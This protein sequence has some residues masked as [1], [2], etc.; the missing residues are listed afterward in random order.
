MTFAKVMLAAVAALA[1][2]TAAA[3]AEPVKLRQGWVVAPADSPLFMFG[4]KGIT[5][6]EGKSY[7]LDTPRFQGTPPMITALAGGELD[8]V[9]FAYSSLGLAIENARMNDLRIIAD[10]FQDGVEGGYTNEYRVRNDSPIK[11]VEDL[12]GKVLAANVNGSALDIA[13][14]AMLR[15]HK[16]EDKRD[17]TIIEVGFPN[18][19]AVLAD[20]KVDLISAVLP[21][22]LDAELNSMS[23]VLFTQKDAIGRSQMIILTAKE[24]FIKKNRAALVDY[25]E[26][27]LRLLRWYEAPA[28]HAEA[29]QLVSAYTKI[30]E[31]ALD[32]WL[33]V[34]GKDYYRDPNAK[35]DINALQANVDLAQQLGFIK[36]KIDIKK[37]V[38]LSLAEEAAKRVK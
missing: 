29:V 16:M 26:D 9:P 33:F 34:K 21:F 6:H 27:Y 22:S 24:S 25:L 23:R 17:V 3:Q 38:D 36:G 37:Y 32:S 20:K 14:R 15:K 2:G 18:M 35:P 31:K 13:L 28:N 7:V 10:I 8:L 5:Q 4:K 19:K 11:T 1:L 12:K 30:P